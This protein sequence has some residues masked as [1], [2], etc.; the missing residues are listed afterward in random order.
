[1]VRSPSR[2]HTWCQLE[3]VQDLACRRPGR[4]AFLG[5]E[6]VLLPAAG[7]WFQWKRRSSRSRAWWHLLGTGSSRTLRPCGA[8]Q[9]QTK[10]HVW[11]TKTLNGNSAPTQKA[12]Q[13]EGAIKTCREL[14]E[15]VEERL[16]ASVLQL[17]K[18]LHQLTNGLITEPT[19]RGTYFRTISQQE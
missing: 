13:S 9:T 3:P 10:R 11:T 2:L 18:Q 6:C 16:L 8:A 12:C 4:R 14:R 5:T 7:C 1:M 17:L 15:A 19:R